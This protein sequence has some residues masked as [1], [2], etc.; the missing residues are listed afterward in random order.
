MEPKRIV[1][2][3]SGGVDSSVSLLLLK[4]QGWSPVGVSLKLAHWEHPANVRGENACCTADSLAIAR[5]VCERLGVEHH[6]Y[7]VSAEFRRVVMDYFVAE[8][9]ANRT[10]NPCIICN[11]HLKFRKLLEWARK[12]G[13]GHVASGHYAKVRLNAGTGRYELLRPKDLV[14]DQSYGLSFLGQEQLKHLVLPLADYTKAEVYRIA[15]E[16]GFGFFLKRRQSQDLCFVTKKAYPLYLTEELGEKPGQIV[17]TDGNVL[18]KHRGLHFYSPGKRK[19][20]GLKDKY[21]VKGFDRKKNALIVVKDRGEAV[22]SD[23]LLNRFNLISGEV[24]KRKLRVQAKVRYLGG[25]SDATLYPAEKGRMRIVF[26][27]PQQFVAPGQFCVFYQDD[28]CLGAGI[29]YK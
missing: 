26:D 17:D 7:D 16:Q 4:Q 9:K 19:G 25:L 15:K 14:K 8:L 6:V 10:P 23:I 2:G 11:R 28:V 24:H 5:G 22:Q 12:R 13:I 29:I 21:F 27:T 18:G 1:V 20:L 3:M